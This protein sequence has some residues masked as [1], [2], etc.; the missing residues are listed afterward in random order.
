[1][2]TL[3]DAIWEECFSHGGWISFSQIYNKVSDKVGSFTLG[4]QEVRN[5]LGEMMPEKD[6]YFDESPG[7][8]L[9]KVRGK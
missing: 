2:L 1:M 9:Y 3:K 5:V 4:V 7:S 6:I 8:R